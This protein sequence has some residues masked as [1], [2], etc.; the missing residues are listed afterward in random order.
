MKGLNLV[1]AIARLSCVFK[2]K[3]DGLVVDYIGSADDPERALAASGSPR[4]LR[5]A[6]FSRDRRRER[7]G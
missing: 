2:E 1:Q 3:H 7:L 5:E 4:V 6:E